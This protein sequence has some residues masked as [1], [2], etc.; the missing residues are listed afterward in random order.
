M[1][2][3]GYKKEKEHVYVI[4]SKKGRA[5]LREF[6]MKYGITYGNPVHSISRT[7]W[8]L[9][10]LGVTPRKNVKFPYEHLDYEA[11]HSC[12][13]G[14][15]TNLYILG[16]YRNM[17]HQNKTQWVQYLKEKGKVAENIVDNHLAAT[18]NA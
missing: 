3:D 13:Q 17:F 4:M 8:E 10:K 15:L 2:K 1:L 11:Q 7:D 9:H 12:Y 16:Y 14:L 18:Q 5:I 6:Y